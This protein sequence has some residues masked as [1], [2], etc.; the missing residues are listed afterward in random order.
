MRRRMGVSDKA[1]V[2]FWCEDGLGS[3]EARK[4]GP[5]ALTIALGMYGP[6]M[7]CQVSCGLVMGM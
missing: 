7:G 3:S 6:R 4:V 2:W 1:M 5:W